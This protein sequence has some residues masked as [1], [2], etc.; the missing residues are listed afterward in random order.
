MM[1]DRFGGRLARDVWDVLRATAPSHQNLRGRL[2]TAFVATLVVDALASTAMFLL[3][4]N[5]PS[6]HL[7][8]FGHAVY[9]TTAQLTTLS[10]TMSNPV[11]ETGKIITVLLDVYAITVVSTLAGMFSDFFRHRR[12]EQRAPR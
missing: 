2:V 8:N 10:T 9:W 4:G 11:T 12:E 3:E 7:H 6:S 5:L 1:L